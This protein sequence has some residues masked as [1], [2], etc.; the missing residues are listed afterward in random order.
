MEELIKYFCNLLIIQYRNKPKASATVESLVRATFED[1][2]K[3]VFLLEY[4]NSFD[5]DTAELEQ[6]K[7]LAKYIGYSD[8]LNAPEMNY[9]RLSDYEGDDETPG[10]SDY[11]EQYI[12][13]PLLTYSG[14][15]FVDKSLS[16]SVGIVFFR[17]VLKF[18]SEM[19]NE[20][21]SLG[22]LSNLLYKYFGNDIY[23]EEGDKSITYV[24]SDS[25]YQ[26]FNSDATL[27]EVFIKKYMPR[28]MGCTLAV[29]KEN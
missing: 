7:A 14:Y 2:N 21:L 24:Y 8:S 27:F 22:N 20:T 19:K 9:F 13:Y 4:Q 6:L 3:N 28:P 26:Q 11:N 1:I 25:M 12:G 15:T 29:R 23:V 5:L 16:G 17:K 18:L 10:L